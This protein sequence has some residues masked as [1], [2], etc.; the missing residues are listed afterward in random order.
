MDLT[1]CAIASGSSGNSYMVRS[2]ETVLLVDV[3][4]SGKRIKEGLEKGG[5]SLDA[6][7]AILITHEHSDH[8]KSL[9]I[10]Q[11]KCPQAA[12]W[13]NIGTYRKISGEVADGRHHTFTTGEAFRIGDIK[14]YPFPVSHDAAEPVGF[15][16]EKGDSKM[17]IVTDTGYLSD[18]IFEAVRG[19]DLLVLEANH[20]EKVLRVGRYPFHVK[21]RILSDHGHLCNEAAADCIERLLREEDKLPVFLLAHLSKENN[22]PDIALLTVRNAL[23]ASDVFTERVAAGALEDLRIEVL[24]RSEPGNVYQLG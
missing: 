3:G 19:S 6:V 12:V 11:R 7:D 14:V 18:E 22:T 13:S 1:F 10:M 23:E 21:Q 4:I 2:G 24:S 5:A 15:V 20:D 17:A 16:F 8:V 9:G